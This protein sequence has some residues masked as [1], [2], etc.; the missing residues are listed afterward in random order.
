MLEKIKTLE[1]GQVLGG[2]KII[3]IKTDV[4]NDSYHNVGVLFEGDSYM[5]DVYCLTQYYYEEIFGS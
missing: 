1:V 4:K 2:K 5:K 3:D